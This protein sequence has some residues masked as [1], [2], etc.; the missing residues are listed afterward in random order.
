MPRGTTSR[1]YWLS[2]LGQKGEPTKDELMMKANFICANLK[3]RG[4]PS[5]TLLRKD[6]FGDVCIVTTYD[7]YRYPLDNY[8]EVCVKFLCAVLKEEGL[9]FDVNEDSLIPINSTETSNYGP[10][11]YG[12]KDFSYIVRKTEKSSPK[13]TDKAFDEYTKA[14]KELNKKV[15]EDLKKKAIKELKK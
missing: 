12:T 6:G 13:E 10:P 15:I 5:Y 9:E 14:I 8:D 2:T 4:V 1:Y 3:E 7:G 11:I